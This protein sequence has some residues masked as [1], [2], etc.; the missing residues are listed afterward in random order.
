MGCASLAL[1]GLLYGLHC[2]CGVGF[3]YLFNVF[4]IKLILGG[5]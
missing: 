4:F 5:L 3:D 1:L 2:V